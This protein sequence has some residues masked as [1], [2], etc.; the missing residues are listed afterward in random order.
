[1]DFSQLR[2]PAPPLRG[3]FQTKQAL[4]HA[5]LRQAI[6]TGDLAPGERLVIDDLAAALSMSAIPV[7]EA[8]QQLQ[9]EGLITIRPH[10]GAVVA[11]MDKD[12]ISELF[13]LME[14]LELVAVRAAAERIDS[15][16][17][18]RLQTAAA[19]MRAATL[20]GDGDS[21]GNAWASANKE[22]HRTIVS[23]AGLPLVAE[24]TDRVLSQWDRLRRLAYRDVHFDHGDADHEHEAMIAAFAAGNLTSLEDLVVAHNRTPLAGY[25]RSVNEG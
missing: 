3:G 14:A 16:G 2:P 7:R 21:D 11:G 12:A 17:L 1:M 19:A 5:T 20:A 24:F 10:A 13:A 18:S 8:L 23:I 25:L 6:L 22:F 9:Q 4:V 15:A